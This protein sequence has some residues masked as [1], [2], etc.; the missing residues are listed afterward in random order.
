MHDTHV[1]CINVIKGKAKSSAYW[2]ASI[3]Q[4]SV[5]KDWSCRSLCLCIPYFWSL[6]SR[7]VPYMN[8]VIRVLQF[9]NCQRHFINING[10]S[11]EHSLMILR[12]PV[13]KFMGAL[14]SKNP[15]GSMRLRQVYPAWN[16]EAPDMLSN[17]RTSL[18]IWN[19]E[20]MY[21]PVNLSCK[22]ILR[23]LCI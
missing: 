23:E 9:G 6:L 7:Y 18:R 13:N 11:S 4:I 14:L 3:C 10:Q 15:H 5:G 22:L 16:M 19:D 17:C 12:Y 8:V 2:L 1:D 20:A 21:F